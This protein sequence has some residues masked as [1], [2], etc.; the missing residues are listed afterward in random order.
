MRFDD[1]AQ[2]A[3]LAPSDYRSWRF[4]TEHELQLPLHCGIVNIVP[5]LNTSYGY[6]E[7]VV[8][9]GGD[10]VLLTAGVRSSATFWKVY[11][12]YNR[13]WDLNRLRHIIT[14][15]VDVLA[16]FVRT[17]NPGDVLQFDEIDALDD[18]KIIR[19]GL[20]QRLQT[21]RLARSVE[22]AAVGGWYTANWMVLD[23]EL[24]YYPQPAK[25][26][27][28]HDLSPLRIDYLWQLT[29]RLALITKADLRLDAGGR[30]ETYDLG[31]AINRSPKMTF[32]FG[33]HYID[34][35]GSNIL[36][37]QLDYKLNERWSMGLLALYDIGLNQENDYRLV[38]RR[39][40][41]RWILETGV[42]YD[43]GQDDL[44]I[45]FFIMPQGM[46][47]ARFRFY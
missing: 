25:H 10:R 42:E 41:H 26:N 31:V 20:R 12:F 11:N 22:P 24:D 40:L 47:E 38:L 6:Y 16:T 8:E 34:T 45:M 23:L 13:L 35:S 46:S 15:T 44:S 18:T 1:D 21:R 14:P 33:Q 29:D 32:Y 27:R 39:R 7:N 30:L 19:F 37:G 43:A 2:N 28:G 9:G 4:F 36:V 5:F 17:K 3:G